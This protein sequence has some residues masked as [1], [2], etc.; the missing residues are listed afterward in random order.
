MLFRILVQLQRPLAAGHDEGVGAENL[1][2]RALALGQAAL[3]H[4]H[5]LA[6]ALKP[7]HRPGVHPPHPVVKPVGR[8]GKI[9]PGHLL[10]EG[11]GLGG[12]GVV[13]GPGPNLA[14]LDLPD[15]AQESLGP[16]AGDPLKEL[17][18]GLL[19]VDGHRA[20]RENIPGVQPFVQLHDGDAGLLIPVQHR[21]LH[22]RGAP[23]FGQ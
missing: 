22:R 9:Q 4:L 12:P 11:R 17:A 18:A 13:L 16:G 20:D 10:G 23:V 2:R 7:G 8:Q 1:P 14:G 5:P 19:R 21:P 15:A 3:Y 6:A